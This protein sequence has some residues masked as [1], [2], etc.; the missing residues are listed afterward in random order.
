MVKLS[1][2]IITLNEEKN[3]KEAILSLR[4]ICDEIIVVDA[5]SKDNTVKIARELG[6][7]VFQR[8]WDNYVNQRNY[9]I[10]KASGEW[11]LFIDA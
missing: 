10:D 2:I 7:K 9:A 1:G 8:E 11:I 4:K 6:A 5:F 3:I